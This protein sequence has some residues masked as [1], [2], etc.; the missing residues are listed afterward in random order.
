MKQ[1]HSGHIHPNF[2]V[3]SLNSHITIST[4]SMSSWQ[5]WRKAFSLLGIWLFLF[6]QPPFIPWGKPKTPISR[7]DSARISHTTRTL[8]QMSVQLRRNSAQQT[9]AYDEVVRVLYA[10]IILLCALRPQVVYRTCRYCALSWRRRRRQ[11]ISAI[12]LRASTMLC[13]AWRRD[14]Y[15]HRQKIVEKSPVCCA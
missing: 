2:Q 13:A 7:T 5:G 8:L 9:N 1:S 3:P 15:D 10:K 14:V 12:P 11:K 6:A 4:S